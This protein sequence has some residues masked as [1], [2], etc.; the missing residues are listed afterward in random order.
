MVHVVRA[1]VP[2][3]PVVPP[4]SAYTLTCKAPP[5]A[6]SRGDGPKVPGVHGGRVER[7][8]CGRWEGKWV[9]LPGEVQPFQDALSHLFHLGS[10]L[11][12][13]VKCRH[14]KTWF[15][16]LHSNWDREK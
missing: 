6:L 16:R 8:R 2:H 12:L 3:T 9:A 1:P 13:Q 14:V 5:S 11:G 15:T 7:Q 10:L 4:D